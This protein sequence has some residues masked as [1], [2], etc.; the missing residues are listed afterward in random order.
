MRSD[1]AGRGAY[2]IDH[3]ALRPSIPHLIILSMSWFGESGPYQDYRG[4]DAVC[5]AIAGT[6]HLVGPEG[7]PAAFP[8]PDYQ[9]G[10][11]GGLTAFIA[12]DGVAAVRQTQNGGGGS[13]SACWRPTWRSSDYNVALAWAP[14]RQGPAL[15]RQRFAPELSARD[16]PL[17]ARLDRRDR[18]HAGA[19]EDI[20][21]DARACRSG[22]RSALSP[23]TADRLRDADEMEAALRRRA[24]STRT[25]EEWFAHRRSSSACRSWSCPTMADLLASREHRRRNVF[26]ACHA[27]R[28]QL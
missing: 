25:A 24:S 13:R 27:R 14:G 7:R 8:I 11:V 19:V 23:S 1:A 17:Q 15:G 22:R 28:A 4:T 5:R 3:A 20:L 16:L 18:R 9:A 21:P 6:V 26:V 10:P 12:G 2:R